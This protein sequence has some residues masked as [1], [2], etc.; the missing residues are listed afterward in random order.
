M[1]RARVFRMSLDADVVTV[2]L[3]PEWTLITGRVFQWRR[4][5]LRTNGAPLTDTA[6]W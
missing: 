6:G 4:V 1:E 3:L 2:N 5:R